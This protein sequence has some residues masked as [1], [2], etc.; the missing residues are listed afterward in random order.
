MQTMGS[1]SLNKVLLPEGIVD[2]LRVVVF[3]VITGQTGLQ[4]IYANWPD[5]D[6]ELITARTLDG[7]MQL[8]RYVPTLH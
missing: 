5:L 3:P 6:L 7:P 1:I 2:L 8:L 4:P